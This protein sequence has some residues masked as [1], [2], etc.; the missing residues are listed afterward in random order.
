MGLLPRGQ[1]LRSCLLAPQQFPGTSPDRSFRHRVAPTLEPLSR[2]GAIGQTVKKTQTINSTQSEISG[3]YGSNGSKGSNQKV[4][5]SSKA[6]QSFAGFVP[7][8]VLTIA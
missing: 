8:P 1:P 3:S 6:S 5:P 4:Q 7:G 2:M